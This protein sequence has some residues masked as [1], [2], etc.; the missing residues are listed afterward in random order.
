M[1]NL[2]IFKAMLL[3]TEKSGLTIDK[4]MRDVRKFKE[5]LGERMICKS[6]TLAYKSYLLEQYAIASVN[7]MLSSLN[8]Y[9]KYCGRADCCVSII[10]TQRRMFCDE[11]KELTKEEYMRLLAAAKNKSWLSLLMQTIGTTGIRVS[12]HRFIT[13]EAAKSGKAT[14]K[15]KG[16]VRVILLSKKLCQIL[17]LYARQNQIEKG[18]IFVTDRGKPIDRS[19]IWAEMKKLCSS[20]QVLAEKVFP[21]N[22]RHL[23]ARLYYA[24]EKDI[25]RLADVLG[26]SNINTTRIYTVESGREHRR[27]MEKIAKLCIT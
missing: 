7:S 6:E 18:S 3:E 9:L 27:Q 5:W 15:C 11:E 4:Y 24:M 26:H 22:L 19:R 8:S 23:F 25:V 13:V 2:Q 12:E 10:K 1:D 14:V 21:H 16:K 20:A 17:I